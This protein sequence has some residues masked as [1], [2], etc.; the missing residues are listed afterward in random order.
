MIVSTKSTYGT[1]LGRT[2]AHS[3]PRRR[4][5]GI[6]LIL[7]LI[8]LILLSVLGLVMVVSVNSDMMINGYYGN[9]RGSFY[10]A[11][12]GMNIARAALINQTQAAVVMTACP[13]WGA[14]A[15]AGCTAPPLS[16]TAGSDALTAINGVYGNY[17][18]LNAGQ[19]ANSW[20]G[21]FRL[22]NT[23]ACPS[24]VAPGVATPI[25][26]AGASG[27]TEYNFTYKYSLCTLGRAL[28]TQQSYVSETG[29]YIIHVKLPVGPTSSSTSFAAFGAFINNYPPCT[30]PLVPGTMTGPMF[31]N[32]AWQFMTGGAYVFTDPVGQA[33]AN[34]D[35]YFGSKCIQSPTSTYSYNGQTI[36]PTFQG[37]LN[38]NQNTAPL[39]VNDFSQKWAVL[40]GKGCG[41]G[42]NVCG[43]S[44][45]PAPPAVTNA[46][47]NATL[48]NVSGTAYPLGGA[49]SGVYVP[50][51]C[52]GTS[53]C[54]NTVTGGGIY[55]EGSAGVVMSVGTDSAIP[56]NP[57][58]I[59]SI[60]Q[61]STTTTITTNINAN[62]T[63]VVS[64]GT[65]L[66]L[67]G[68]FQNLTGTNP[69]PATML[70]VNGTITGLSGTGQGVPAIQDYSQITIT[71]AGTVNITGDLVYKHEP[72]TMTTA[73]TLVQGA[74][75]NQV[76]GIFTATGNINLKSPYSN[77]NLQV[78]G[79]L[80]ALSQSCSSS[81]CGFT[82]SGSIN[83]FNNVGGQIQYNIFSANMQTEN[84]WFDRRFTSK[85]GFAPPWFPST[86]M[87]S[88]GPASVVP[89]PDH[90]QQ[91][92]SWLATPQ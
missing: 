11:D 42:T 52:V 56:P 36:K 59:Y 4:E 87:Q 83:T 8:M 45:S 10:A 39:P 63:T 23:A 50:Y 13:G 74:D 91:R 30:G 66:N 65:T 46:N 60:T 75:Y 32:G 2:S 69:S 17:T 54:V 15:P 47:L 78:D 41:E 27:F 85:V 73:D 25:G 22:I 31:T 1:M 55:V 26:T 76:L 18:S 57:T 90:T 88:V 35:Y 21:S 20:Q 84:T 19:A 24:T 3:A 34:A 92:M 72:V 29:N 62:K 58:Q 40:D 33:N 61:G 6:A 70:Y 16:L 28:A 7:A 71:A 64:N 5:R 80:A 9:Y 14:G 77:Q 68:V 51:S 49:S 79:S 44:T 67:T 12:S 81:S 48:K 89:Q 43:V 53:S 38:L 86:T 82:V 37:G